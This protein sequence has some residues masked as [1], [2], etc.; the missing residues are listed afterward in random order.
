M[1]SHSS[2]TP[3]SSSCIERRVS[4]PSAGG[5]VNLVNLRALVWLGLWLSVRSFVSHL[6]ES[7]SPLYLHL[8][9]VSCR[10]GF[11]VSASEVPRCIVYFP[12]LVGS[13]RRTA[14][15]AI[16]RALQ[17]R[18]DSDLHVRNYKQV[19]CMLSISHTVNIDIGTKR[20]SGC[21]QLMLIDQWPR[22]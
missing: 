15:A 8:I 19:I 3:S 11:S 18:I 1:Y 10:P 16:T 14:P 9:L 21:G 4:P 12:I 2:M 20:Q 7:I 13:T 17:S 22:S 6:C 5:R